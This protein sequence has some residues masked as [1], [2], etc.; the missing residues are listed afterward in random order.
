MKK[1]IIRHI[2]I[3]IL[4]IL[5][6]GLLASCKS[7]TIYVPVETV[8]TEYKDSYLRDS[9]YL[10]DSVLIRLKGDTVF[11]EKYKYLYRD[12]LVIDSIFIRDS[13]H[14]PYPVTEYIKE[15]YKSGFDWFQ[16]W[17]GRILL[18]LLIGYIGFKKFL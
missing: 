11:F 16:I 18:L 14:V 5:V 13:I 4:A 6:L 17:C 7:K 9:V 1:N 3:L 12:K 15:N 2:I 8:K 10:H